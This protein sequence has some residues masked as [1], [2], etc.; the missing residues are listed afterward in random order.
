MT[1]NPFSG[2]ELPPADGCKI[3]NSINFFIQTD[4][5]CRMGIEAVEWYAPLLTPDQRRDIVAMA[6][7]KIAKMQGEVQERKEAMEL[8]TSVLNEAM[9]RFEAFRQINADPSNEPNAKEATRKIGS[10]K[11][12]HVL[13]VSKAL[14]EAKRWYEVYS[15]NLKRYEANLKCWVDVI[16]SHM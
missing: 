8:A 12:K 6:D 9:T 7:A 11:Q 1:Q 3:D 2:F 15:S 10:F 13:P 4:Q 16:K 14:E 5:G